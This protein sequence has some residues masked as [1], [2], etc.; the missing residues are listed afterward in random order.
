MTGCTGKIKINKKVFAS[1]DF[2]TASAYRRY[3]NKTKINKQTESMYVFTLS[4]ANM[5]YTVECQSYF[6]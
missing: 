4:N 5:S 6:A 2:L 3:F 1:I